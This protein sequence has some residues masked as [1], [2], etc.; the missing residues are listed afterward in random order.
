MTI[1]L[2]LD[3]ALPLTAAD[4]ATAWNDTPACA[5]ADVATADPAAYF[6]PPEL[7]A[8]GLV[9]L[10]DIS[11][12]VAG[13][14]LYD[15]IKTALA[16]RSVKKTTEIIQIEQPDGTKVLVVRIVES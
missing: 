15:L 14:A 16:R 10:S 12:G 7:L 2:A 4:F 5:A 13:N 6:L 8:V 3:P 1:Q 11:V 9:V